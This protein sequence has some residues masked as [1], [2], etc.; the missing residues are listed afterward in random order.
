MLCIFLDNARH[1]GDANS[2]IT[3]YK[4][5]HH[6]CSLLAAPCARTKLISFTIQDHWKGISAE[7]KSFILDRLFQADKSRMHTLH[8]GLGLSIFQELVNMHRGK[9]TLADTQAGGCMFTI[10]FLHSDT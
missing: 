7:D 8:F 3:V 6:P 2:T 1:Y 5:Q 9:I 4:E 10:Y